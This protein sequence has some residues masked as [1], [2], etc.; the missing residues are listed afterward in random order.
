M[1]SLEKLQQKISQWREIH[2]AL[3]EENKKLKEEL[4]IK[5]I[6]IEKIIEQVQ[7]LLDA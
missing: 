4:D 3:K 5:E 1:S 7:E 2:E 6:E